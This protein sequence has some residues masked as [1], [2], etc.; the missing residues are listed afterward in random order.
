MNYKIR[1]ALSVLRYII[2]TLRFNF[3]Y[4]PFR[5]AVKLP[6]LL[7]KPRLLN[8]KGTVSIEGPVHTGM[9]KL[10][11]EYAKLYPN[12]GIQFENGGGKVIFEGEALIGGSSFISIGTHGCLRLGARFAN[13]AQLRIACYHSITVG[14]RTGFGYDVLMMDTNCHRMKNE[15]GE[16]V[17]SG[18]APIVIGEYNWIGTRCMVMP[19]AHTAPFTTVAANS[20]INRTFTESR[21]IVAGSPAVIKKRGIWRDRDDDQIDYEAIAAAQSQA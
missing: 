3:H 17:S 18:V 15:D 10:G 4:L 14:Y 12:A 11:F 5:Q 16:F 8:M 7:Y 20:L 6:I 1:R 13:N 9:I 2:P 21:I 19:G